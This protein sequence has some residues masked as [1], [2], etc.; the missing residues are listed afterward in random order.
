MSVARSHVFVSRV[1]RLEAMNLALDRELRRLAQTIGTTETALLTE[2][3]R[4]HL[5][6]REQAEPAG[7]RMRANIALLTC[8]A[9]GRRFLDAL[10][11]AAAVELVHNFSLVFD[12]VQDGDALRRGRPSVWK[13]WGAGQAINAGAALEAL[14]TKAVV[15]LLPARHEEHLR[16]ALLLLTTAMV[17]LCRGQVLD[18]EFEQRV[19]VNVD[20]YLVMVGLKTAGLFECAARLGALSA[21][22]GDA[23]MD[24]AGAFG[25]HL[26]IAYQIIDDIHGIWG[27]ER[28]TGK[29][30]GS[31][32]RNGKKTLPAI[33]ALRQG[34]VKGRRELRSLLTRATFKPP[35]MDA[36]RVILAQAN[37]R[38]LSRRQAAEHLAEARLNLF[39]LSSRPNWAMRALA[40]MVLTL[41]SGLSQPIS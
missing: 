11:A 29:P 16:P 26:G 39:A 9:M 28:Q 13:V 27:S 18:L 6:L 12:D 20:E 15:D 36:A 17:G 8:E 31:D 40:E 34:P 37:A 24:R 23:A 33:I 22:A 41:E 32:L 10:W 30:V 14:V 2:M 1:S 38:E 4:Y 35:E 7:K 3:V 25:R 19:D 21:G 5:G